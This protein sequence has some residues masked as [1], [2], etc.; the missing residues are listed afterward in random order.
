[1]FNEE[2]KR[3]I[4][5]QMNRVVESCLKDVDKY[6]WNDEATAGADDCIEMAEEIKSILLGS[7]GYNY[8]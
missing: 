8:E 7:E 4:I 2:Q 1:M 6:G 3:F 5:I